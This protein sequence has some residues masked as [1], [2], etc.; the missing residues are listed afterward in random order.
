LRD[1]NL[2]LSSL[3]ELGVGMSQLPESK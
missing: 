1:R 3:A 2:L